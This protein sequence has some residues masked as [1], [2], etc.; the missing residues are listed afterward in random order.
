LLKLPNK[1]HGYRPDQAGVFVRFNVN[2]DKDYVGKLFCLIIDYGEI[3]A[4]N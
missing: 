4:N 3:F 1:P 2:V